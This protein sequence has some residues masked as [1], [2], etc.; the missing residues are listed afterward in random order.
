MTPTPT[1]TPETHDFAQPP[2]FYRR[3]DTDAINLTIDTGN[4]RDSQSKH[5]FSRYVRIELP[6]R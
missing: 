3:K 1:T 5:N 4:F 2:I 6:P